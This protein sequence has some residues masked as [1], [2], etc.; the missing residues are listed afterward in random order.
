MQLSG[1][2]PSDHS[3]TSSTRCPSSAADLH[4]QASGGQL[5]VVALVQAVLPHQRRQVLQ[6]VSVSVRGGDVQEVVAVLVP[7]ELQVIGGQVRLEEEDKEEEFSS[8]VFI[9]TR[10]CKT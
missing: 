3:V 5:L 2:A 1:R 4:S 8:C 6:T 10:I 7:D 9:A